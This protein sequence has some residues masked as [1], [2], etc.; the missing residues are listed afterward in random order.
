MTKLNTIF[1]TCKFSVAG[2]RAYVPI[3]GDRQKTKE[4]SRLN[5][6]DHLTG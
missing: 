6:S 2:L 5:S 4:R 3:N 1:S